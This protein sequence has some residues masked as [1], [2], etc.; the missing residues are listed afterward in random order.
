MELRVAPCGSR[1]ANGR[2]FRICETI[3]AQAGAGGWAL[4]PSHGSAHA[5]RP[6][7]RAPAVI[8]LA[9]ALPGRQEP[10]G[11]QALQVASLSA[12]HFAAASSA[13]MF[14]FVM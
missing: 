6:A 1:L 3:G 12:I 8:C 13:D 5:K 10:A 4:A 11:S 7:P 9:E 2:W 14:S